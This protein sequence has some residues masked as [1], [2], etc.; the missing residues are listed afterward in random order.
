MT[1]LSYEASDYPVPDR[2]LEAH[3]RYW[4]RLARAGCWFSGAE[5]VAIAREVRLA[6]SC[7]LCQRRKDALSAA[8]VQGE[9]E[10]GDVLT[11]VVI[12]TI[13]RITT[14]P[15]RLTRSWYDGLL[16]QGLTEEQYVEIL[17]T[18]VATLSIDDFCIGI[19]V[20][21]HPLP[22][23][24]GGDAT[25]YRPPGATHSDAWVSMI[26]EKGAT[27]AEA[28]LY[29]G[30]PRAANVI[31]AMSLVPDEVRTLNDLGNVQYVPA[32]QAMNVKA[33]YG[34]LSRAQI[35]LIAGRVSA[36][37]SCFY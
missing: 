13:H 22:N 4:T 1:S 30:V 2:Y 31:K 35:E 21:E 5:R 36:L 23:P 16:S 25:Q 6:R 15:G 28:D 26:Q 12:E 8:Q 17:G 18:L 33:S 27:G 32:A 34:G 19:G 14:D 3:Q 37:N 29:S 7:S 10:G 24:V 20:P 11:D 9:H